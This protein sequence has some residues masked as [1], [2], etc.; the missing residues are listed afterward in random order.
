LSPGP[1]GSSLGWNIIDNSNGDNLGVTFDFL[2]TLGETELLSSPRVT[3]MNQKPAVIADVTE[4]YF[5]I[6]LITQVVAIQGTQGTTSNTATSSFSQPILESFIFGYTLSVTPYIADNKVRLWL[7][8]QV[9]E[10]LGEK[11]FVVNNTINGEPQSSILTFPTVGTQSVW[12]N[13]N[14]SD[15]DTL[16]LGGLITDKSIKEEN[17]VPYL[18]KIPVIGF[19]FR[20][21]SKQVDQGSLLIFVTPTIIDPSGSRYF[22]PAE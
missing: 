12:T 8:P 9:T 11:T 17:K 1:T 2:N 18:S 22:A 21:K 10:K 7:N 3:T 5:Q 20:G 6:G 15:G 13:V 4:E 19:F 16:V 14:V